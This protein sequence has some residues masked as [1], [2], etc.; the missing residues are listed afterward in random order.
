VRRKQC[1]AVARSSDW[2]LS[3]SWH[4]DERG[5]ISRSLNPGRR[6]INE[7]RADVTNLVPFNQGFGGFG[8]SRESRELSRVQTRALGEV[9]IASRVVAMKEQYRAELA[10]QALTNVGALSALEQSIVQSVPEAAPR[11]RRIVDAYTMGAINTLM[12]F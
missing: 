4:P 3:Q 11:V 1:F 12:R 5:F 2:T 9:E 6:I 8:Q 7:R 10:N